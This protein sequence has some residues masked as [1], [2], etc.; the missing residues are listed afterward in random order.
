MKVGIHIDRSV[1]E[2]EVLITAQERNRKVDAL[3]QHI[4]EFDKSRL[5]TLTAYR[6]DIAKIVNVADIFRIYTGNQKVYIQT[7]QGEYVIRYR[8]GII[9]VG[10][11][12]DTGSRCFLGRICSLQKYKRIIISERYRESAQK[13][14][15]AGNSCN[16]I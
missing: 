10:K 4:V 1:E 11:F 12:S 3:Y 5:E 14:E 13:L 7:H 16:G 15:G 6:D 2:I 8:F 9:S